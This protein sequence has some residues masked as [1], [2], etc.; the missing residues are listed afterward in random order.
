MRIHRNKS[1]AGQR[2]RVGPY[3]AV[4]L[5]GSGSFAD[6]YRAV[7]AG[8]D[9]DR[10][11][12]SVAIKILR[13]PWRDRAEYREM[14]R[15][16]A[17]L[18]YGLRCPSVIPVLDVS[19]PEST[20]PWFVMPWAERGTLAGRLDWLSRRS[21]VPTFRQVVEIS[22]AITA[23]VQQL[24]SEGVVH[25]DLKPGN[26]LLGRSA[27]FGT[28]ETA[29]AIKR[30]ERLLVAD[31]GIARRI[32]SSHTPEGTGFR[33]GTLAY[34]APEMGTAR[35][36]D[37]RADLY[38]CARVVQRLLTGDDPLPSALV[39]ADSFATI[40]DGLRGLLDAATAADPASRPGTLT[41]WQAMLRSAVAERGLRGPVHGWRN[42]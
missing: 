18:L 24:H 15:E 4:E 23:A 28:A 37:E 2:Q 6:V 30:D 36:V 26:L 8:D 13:S 41:E 32:H 22:G 38:S 33:A 3:V 35:L 21:W 20:Q 11:D 17:T 5:S 10:P 29:P 1:S 19:P 25:G 9:E 27:P 7:R 31:L 12:R 40:P 42:P 16:E 34:S 14:F 39:S